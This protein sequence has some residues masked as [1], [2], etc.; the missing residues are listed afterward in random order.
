[1]AGNFALPKAWNECR[2]GKRWAKISFARIYFCIDADHWD[3]GL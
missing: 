2:Q 1:M 3:E